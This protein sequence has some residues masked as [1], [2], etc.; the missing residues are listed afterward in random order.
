MDA[1]HKQTEKLLKCP[2][3]DKKENS[4]YQDGKNLNKKNPIASQTYIKLKFP[5]QNKL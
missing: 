1:P 5:L 4:I 2:I 3:L